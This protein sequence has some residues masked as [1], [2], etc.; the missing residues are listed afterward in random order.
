MDIY[1]HPLGCREADVAAVQVADQLEEHQ[2]G[3]EEEVQLAHQG[4]LPRLAGRVDAAAAAL[5]AGV[6]LKVGRR[7]LCA[8]EF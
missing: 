8:G 2:D 6:L 7:F 3:S 4:L 1:R 5:R